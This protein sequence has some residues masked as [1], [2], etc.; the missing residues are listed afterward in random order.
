MPKT[1]LP[2]LQ[3][4]IA[5]F[6]DE[7]LGALLVTTSPVNFTYDWLDRTKYGLST[8]SIQMLAGLLP[9]MHFGHH[10]CKRVAISRSA[11]KSV[12]C[13]YY[14]RPPVRLELPEYMAHIE[15]NYRSMYARIRCGITS[16]RNAADY[17]QMEEWKFKAVLRLFLDY[18]YGAAPTM[19]EIEIT[20]ERIVL[21]L[22]TGNIVIQ[23]IN[24]YDLNFD[25]ST[26]EGLN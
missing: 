25:W 11:G 2:Y 17:F 9:P 3:K 14:M 15:A 24:Q 19:D 10:L 26:V 16:L 13:R 22:A 1:S 12:K 7:M 23:E 6:G 4:A 20:P 5:Y 8:F 18:V 21:K